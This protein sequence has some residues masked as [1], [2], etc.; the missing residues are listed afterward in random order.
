M[1][2]FCLATNDYCVMTTR[3]LL[4]AVL[5]LLLAACAP[6]TAAATPRLLHVFVSSAAYPRVGDLYACA[7]ASLALGL[8][9]PAAAELTMRVGEP[10]G[11]ASPAYQVGTDDL[12]IVNDV[13]A[14]VGALTLDQVRDLF[15]GR[16]TNWKDAGGNDLPVQVWT[17]APGEDI[18][19]LF[20]RLVMNGQPVASGARLAVSSQAMSDSVGSTPGSIGYLVRRWKTGNTREALQVASVP[21]L[22]I[23]RDEPGPAL[24]QLIDCMQHK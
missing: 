24:K 20:Q 10:E 22:L 9:A 23:A 7:P 15:S 13:Q 3:R 8:S 16:I 17:Y 1:G 14:G 12:L 11:L 18:Q 19:Q 6:S 2:N 5:A 21:V 4:I